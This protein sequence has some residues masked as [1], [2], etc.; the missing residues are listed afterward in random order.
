ME[1]SSGSFWKNYSE[2]VDFFIIMNNRIQERKE[3]QY[4]KKFI[5]G[6]LKYP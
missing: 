6:S 1:S 2:T 3:D 5:K 4:Q